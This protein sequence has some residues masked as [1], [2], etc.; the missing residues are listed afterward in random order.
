MLPF[1]T[2]RLML[3][4]PRITD[5][6]PLTEMWTDA[7]VAQF[8]DDYGPRDPAGVQEWL[9]Q[10]V[11]ALEDCPESNPSSVQLTLARKD[12]AAVVGWLGLGAS[13]R[14]VADWDFGYA[15][16]PAHRGNGYAAEAL[17][18]AVDGCRR[19][20]GIET[21]WGEC[22]RANAASARVMTRAGFSEIASSD[23]GNRRFVLGSST[24]LA[25]A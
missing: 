3:R 9:T 16:H 18:G 6:Q 17:A 25:S 24:A 14:G 21:F 20:F 8:M 22:H 10:I 19:R 13:S 23:D 5:L 15:V 12:D 2:S 4:D 1:E 7:A 11:R